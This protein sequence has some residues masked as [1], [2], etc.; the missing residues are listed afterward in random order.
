MLKKLLIVVALIFISFPA[1]AKFTSPFKG[2]LVPA[3]IEGEVGRIVTLTLTL[4]TVE[5]FHTVEVAIKLPKGLELINGKK[6]ARVVN[7]APGEKKEFSYRIRVKEKG[8]HE[9][10]IGVK[11]RDLRE[12]LGQGTTFV[13]FINPAPV[14]DNGTHTVDSDGT[15]AIV[16]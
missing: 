16:K 1:L 2:A 10:I 15:R 6:V 3:T 11:T 5:K 7:F 13:S 14:K 4:E 12:G 9:V 8:E